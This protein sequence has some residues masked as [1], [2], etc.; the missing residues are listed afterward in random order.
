MYMKVFP[1]GTGRGE[2]VTNY[3]M[4]IERYNRQNS[5]PQVV[6]GDVGLTTDLIN[7]LD[8][9]WK[10]TSGVLSWHPEDKVTPQQEQE[11]IKSFEKMAC[12]GLEQDQYNIL[13]VRH[14][15]TQHHEL[16]FV[17]PR[18]ELA[19]GKAFNACP[20]GWQK[21]FDIW[22]DLHNLQEEWA[23]PDDPARAKTHSPSRAEIQELKLKEMG[24]TS[25]QGEL[26]AIRKELINYTLEK[27]QLGAITDRKDIVNSFKELGF[28]VPRQ[29][30]DYI[31]VHDQD[32]GKRIRLKGGIFCESWRITTENEATTTNREAANGASRQRELTRLRE[33]LEGIHAR[34]GAYNKARYAN[35][36]Q[37]YKDIHQIQPQNIPLQRHSLL[38]LNHR[39]SLGELGSI[40]ISTRRNIAKNAR[41]G[42]FT[43]SDSREISPFGEN[44][45]G[46]ST[47]GKTLPSHTDFGRGGSSRKE[48]GWTP[49]ENTHFTPRHESGNGVATTGQGSHKTYTKVDIYERNNNLS[50]AESGTNADR[51][52]RDFSKRSTDSS[53]LQGADSESGIRSVRTND[54]FVRTIRSIACRNDAMGTAFEKLSQILRRL[55]RAISRASE[56]HHA[57]QIGKTNSSYR[58]R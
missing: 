41:S 5:P 47:A 58:G 49:R 35:N 10:Y 25:K 52:Q 16:H 4:S 12:A 19:T 48:Q 31:T 17:I 42:N 2:G 51:A 27:I 24:K 21:D 56:S 46:Y 33:K 30:K 55:T 37:S 44:R 34:R 18:V 3:L 32:N 45:N 40:G 11:I 54:S 14:S 50:H 22:R 36:Q 39:H 6:R 23:R 9:K 53:S 20:P 26:H 43:L 29:G 15:H 1:T 38:L 57:M 13:W 8:T 28:Q 7:S